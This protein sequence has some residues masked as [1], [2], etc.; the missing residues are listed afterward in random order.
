MQEPYSEEYGEV[1]IFNDCKRG[2]LGYQDPG[3][4]ARCLCHASMHDQSCMAT[5]YR[6]ARPV[7]LL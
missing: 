2:S 6:L 1:V 5:S 3:G 7:P 4:I